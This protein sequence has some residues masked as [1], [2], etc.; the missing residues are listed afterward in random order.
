MSHPSNTNLHLRAPLD[1]QKTLGGDMSICLITRLPL[2]TRFAS[3]EQQQ[4]KGL[5]FETIVSIHFPP[6][7]WLNNT[8]Y[9]VLRLE[10]DDDNANSALFSLNLSVYDQLIKPH[11]WDDM[12]FFLYGLVHPYALTWEVADN[13]AGSG[14]DTQ[15]YTIPSLVVRDLCY[16]PSVS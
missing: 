10:Q 11:D 14:A 13:S 4:F 12:H 5:N 6:P 8:E 7:A 9:T 16:Q 1:N 2:P 15:Q 3:P